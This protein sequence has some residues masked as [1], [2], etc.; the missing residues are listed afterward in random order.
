MLRSLIAIGLMAVTIANAQYTVR[1]DSQSGIQFEA[2]DVQGA[3]LNPGE[4]SGFA[5]QHTFIVWYSDETETTELGRSEFETIENGTGIVS[6]TGSVEGV[7]FLGDFVTQGG[8]ENSMTN[9]VAGVVGS[10]TD[11]FG[12]SFDPLVGLVVVGIGI[13]IA[14]GL[15]KR[16]FGGRPHI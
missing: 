9:T 7:E 2:G 5:P 14:I 1:N 4:S 3:F 16:F 15:S 13:L 12:A 6:W 11:A 8:G 10:I